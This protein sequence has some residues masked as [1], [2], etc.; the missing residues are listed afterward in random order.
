MLDV[1]DARVRI[2]D[3]VVEPMIVCPA[4]HVVVQRTDDPDLVGDGT[5]H[6]L[7]AAEQAG[8]FSRE[9]GEHDCGRLRV[10]REE[11]RRLQQRRGAR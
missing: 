2:A 11:A 3:R 9:R 8:F 5:A 7:A 4:D 1:A 10:L 6:E